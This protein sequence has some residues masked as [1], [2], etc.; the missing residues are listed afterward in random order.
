MDGIDGKERKVLES[1]GEV[2]RQLDKLR[3]QHAMTASMI[4]TLMHDLPQEMRLQYRLEKLTEYMSHI[5]I[6]DLQ[7]K[8]YIRRGYDNATEQGKWR[9]ERHTLENFA[10]WVVSHQPSSIRGLMDSIHY[11]FVSHKFR[12]KRS[13]LL[14]K[15]LF[16][17]IKDIMQESRTNMCNLQQSLQQ[18]LYNLYNSVAITELK[19][20]AMMQFSWMLL[21]LYEKGMFLN[22]FLLCAEDVKNRTWMFGT[23]RNSDKGKERVELP[24]PVSDIGSFVASSA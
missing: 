13:P 24:S 9:L 7:L 15:G 3:E 4:N 12:E 23:V 2:T 8:R 10:T 6:K 19:G 5:D 1:I 20:Y 18:L 21:R 14:G 11:L 16:T 22:Q 17:N